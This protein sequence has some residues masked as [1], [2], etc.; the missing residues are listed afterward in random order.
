[1]KL[2]CLI[3]DDEDLARSVVENYLKDIDFIEIAGSCSNAMEA[4]NKLNSC[5]IDLIFLDINMPGI[6][7]L[8]LLRTLK[9]PPKII[10][11]T[12]YREYAVEGFELDVVDYI[13]KPF[14][15]SR[16]LLAI[17]RAAER[18]K[19]EQSAM[20]SAPT[21]VIE[22][23]AAEAYIFIKSNK[24]TY[25][26]TMDEILFVEAISDYV[27][28]ITEKTSLISY[29]YLKDIEKMLEPSLFPRVH[30]SFLVSVSK[31][32]SIEGNM[33]KIGKT[34]IPIGRNYRERFI[35]LL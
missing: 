5:K 34:T 12:A 27:K 11:T 2:K 17:N 10:I 32:D 28:I 31:I 1:M 7:G 18:I 13:C 16:F 21:Q 25:R 26:V 29:M 6:D 30:K 8:S 9:S 15:F 3:V 33:I 19:T 35:A 22:H 4:L 20:A 23:K 14:P 24:K